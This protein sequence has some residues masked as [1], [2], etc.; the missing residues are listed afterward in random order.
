[1]SIGV[2]RLLRR[3]FGRERKGFSRHH[4]LF[5]GKTGL[6]IGGPSD[7]FR[8]DG[9]LPVYPLAERVDG[10]N[11]SHQTVWEGR[12]SEGDNYRFAEGKVGRQYLCE[13]SRLDVI[14]D[15]T[16]DFVLAS[17]SLEHSANALRCIAEW[18]RVL[19]PAG[20]MLLV[21]PDKQHTFDHRRSVTTF[22]HLL[23]DQRA[24]VGEDDLTH[25]D[26][27]L[28]LHDR[29]MD[30]PSGDLEQFR[31]RSLKNFENRCLHQ[32]VFDE[33]LLRRIFSHFRIELVYADVAPPF[34][35]IVLGVVR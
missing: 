13:G 33:A 11:F 35:I 7:I 29:T 8:A 1:M 34:H 2:G 23:D 28:A 5:E 14:A 21:V 25:L 17:H 16:Y 27:I 4:A 19:R 31:A 10:V 26:E 3:V 6:E 18:K 9:E 20:A 32:H 12:L 15:G 24:D 22:E 30:P